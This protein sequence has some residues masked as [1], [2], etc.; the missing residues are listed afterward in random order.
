MYKKSIIKM[1]RIKDGEFMEPLPIRKI[2]D[3]INSGEIRIP[4]FQ[5]GF[6]WEPE[7]VAYF[8][9]SIYKD[10]PVGSILLWRT[11]VQLKNERKLGRFDLPP[12]TKDYPIDYVLDGQQRLTSIFSVF[13]TGLKPVDDDNWLD[14][15]YLIGSQ[16][17]PQLSMFVALEPEN[18][19]LAKHFPISVFFET[20][21]Y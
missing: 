15:Y 9:D 13:Q 17:N 16:N 3:R 8:M 21:Q 1:W 7:R 11:K 10:Y 5:R 18:V 2:I 4:S 14:I 19:D 20:V 6:V 12:P